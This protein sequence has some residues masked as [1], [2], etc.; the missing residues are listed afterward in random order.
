[1]SAPD[2]TPIYR[3]LHLDNLDTCLRRGALFAPNHTP[4][5]KLAYRTIHNLEIQQR[6]KLT[7]ITCGPR[8]VI[9][10]YV[11]FYFGPRSPMLYQLHTGHVKGYTEG[12]EPLIYLVSTVQT[13][14]EN[15]AK[16]V[17]SDGHGIAR[18]TNWFDKLAKLSKVDW[19]AVNATWWNDT[20]EDMDRQRRKQAEFLIHQ[21]CAWSL[22]EGIGVL[23]K[24]VKSKVEQILAPFPKK[25]RPP[26]NVRP[27]WYY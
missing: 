26:V 11:A 20:V 8:G 24:A 5:D 15:S 17:F 6:R 25:L 7:S 27:D 22:I 3:F 23:N 12:Q 10:D 16:F 1:M 21:K 2:P 9:H 4:N 14:N 18:F 13:V 19:D